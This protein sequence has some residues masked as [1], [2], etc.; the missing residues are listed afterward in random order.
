MVSFYYNVLNCVMRLSSDA[1]PKSDLALI[2]CRIKFPYK[3]K[4]KFHHTAFLDK[5]Y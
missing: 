3:K 4:A 1:K 5:V 2:L